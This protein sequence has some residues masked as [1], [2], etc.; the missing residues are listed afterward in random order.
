MPFMT[1]AGAL[2]T[3][4]AGQRQNVLISNLVCDPRKVTVDKF[5]HSWKAKLSIFLTDEGMVIS[6]S[7]EQLVKQADPIQD[8]PSSRI[9]SL[10]E[11]HPEKQPFS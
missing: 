9:T 5:L 10:R 8:I 11:S 6:L 2:T 1:D 4:K 7:E 3:V